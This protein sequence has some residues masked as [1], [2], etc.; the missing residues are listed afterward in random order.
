MRSGATLGE[1]EKASILIFYPS[2][3]LGFRFI[4]L[5]EAVQSSRSPCGFCGTA[6][7]VQRAGPR[8]PVVF[9]FN[10]EISVPTQAY[11]RNAVIVRGQPEV[12]HIHI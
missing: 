2:L 7:L 8:D 12:V 5:I 3:L 9:V 6:D 10:A 11:C 4:M 1:F